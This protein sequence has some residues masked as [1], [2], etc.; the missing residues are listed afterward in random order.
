MDVINNISSV[1][2]IHEFDG[3]CVNGLESL[4]HSKLGTLV[5]WKFVDA[6]KQRLQC[7]ESAGVALNDHV[8]LVA[9]IFALEQRLFIPKD[10]VIQRNATSSAASQLTDSFESV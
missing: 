3:M 1:V 7:S 2:S 4:R 10:R 8:Q 6:L 5:G 9:V